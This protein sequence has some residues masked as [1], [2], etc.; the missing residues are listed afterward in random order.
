MLTYATIEVQFSCERTLMDM[1]NWSRIVQHF[2]LAIDIVASI[3][4]HCILMHHRDSQDRHMFC[5][6]DNF[7]P[8]LYLYTTYLQLPLLNTLLQGGLI[9]IYCLFKNNFVILFFLFYCIRK[10][11]HMEN[12]SFLLRVEIVHNDAYHFK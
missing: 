1:T 3:V 4:L 5:T 8:Q 9:Y 7:S 11:M 6:A 2:T 12:N 10:Q